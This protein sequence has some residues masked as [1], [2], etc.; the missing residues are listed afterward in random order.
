MVIVPFDATRKLGL[1]RKMFYKLPGFSARTIPSN[2]ADSEAQWKLS[3]SQIMST[4]SLRCSSR[5]V[6]ATNLHDISGCSLRITGVIEHAQQVDLGHGYH[7]HRRNK[8]GRF[9]SNQLNGQTTRLMSGSL[10]D[11]VQPTFT[12]EGAAATTRDLFDPSKLPNKETAT[13]SWS[14]RQK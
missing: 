3:S 5:T 7:R 8:D 6:F 12:R 13:R 4:T 1:I 11:R 2:A 9:C 14:G 10:Q